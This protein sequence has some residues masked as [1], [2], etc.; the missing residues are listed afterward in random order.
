MK[1]IKHI[2]IVE[3][4]SSSAQLL[5]KYLKDYVATKEFEIQ[6]FLFSTVNAFKNSTFKNFLLAK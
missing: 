3:D 4:D 6:I 2:A 5:E 1:D